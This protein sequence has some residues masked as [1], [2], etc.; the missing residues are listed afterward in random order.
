MSGEPT[1]LVELLRSMLNRNFASINNPQLFR[2]P[3]TGTKEQVNAATICAATL[4]AVTLLNTNV[5][6]F[7]SRRSRNSF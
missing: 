5:D 7:L 2:F 6:L 3:A 1:K 4:R